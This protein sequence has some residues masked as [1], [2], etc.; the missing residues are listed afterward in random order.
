MITLSDSEVKSDIHNS[1]L[2]MKK[3]KKTRRGKPKRWCAYDL[4]DSRPD[5]RCGCGNLTPPNSPCAS[6]VHMG[7]RSPTTLVSPARRSPRSKASRKQAC[8]RIRPQ[9]SPGAPHNTNDFIMDDKL[10]FEGVA[11]GN[12]FTMETE[13]FDYDSHLANLFS[14]PAFQLSQQSSASSGPTNTSCPLDSDGDSQY[15]SSTDT[16]ESDCSDSHLA[17]QQAEFELEYQSAWCEPQDPVL[18]VHHSL[19]RS[20]LMQ[21]IQALSFRLTEL[22]QPRPQCPDV[23]ST[24]QCQEPVDVISSLQAEL[25]RLIAANQQLRAENDALK[26]N[27]SKSGLL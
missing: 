15:N 14:S 3:V 7:A 4:L 19:S 9:Y 27:P 6:P 2:K 12:L 5:M 8:P 21:N 23:T 20:Q 10:Q 25:S 11:N 13:S 26:Q 24:S 16:Y 1:D 18:S 22:E 17:Y